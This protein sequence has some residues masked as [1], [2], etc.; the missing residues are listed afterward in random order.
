MRSVGIWI[1]CT[2]VGI[3]ASFSAAWLLWQIALLLTSEWGGA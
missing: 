3:I 1:L 2:I